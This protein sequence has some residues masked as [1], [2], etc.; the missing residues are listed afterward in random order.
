MKS[1]G[2][3]AILSFF[4]A[5]LGQFYNGQFGKG[6]LFMVVQALN[7]AL[8][9]VVIGFITYPIFALW[10]IIDAYKGAE[11]HNASISGGA[12]PQ[13]STNV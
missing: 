8:M 9:F 11:R 4:F 10:G 12:A 2:L 3:A 13:T 7:V 6:V 1:T 5:G